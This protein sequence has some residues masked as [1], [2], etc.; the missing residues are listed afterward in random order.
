MKSFS[1]RAVENLSV[2]EDILNVMAKWASFSLYMEMINQHEISCRGIRNSIAASE[3]E[4]NNADIKRGT[5][6]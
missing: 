1:L 3:E 6:R 5:L 4:M 2:E